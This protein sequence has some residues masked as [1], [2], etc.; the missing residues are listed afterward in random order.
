MR[1]KGSE[2]PPREPKECDHHRVQAKAC[3]F[4]GSRG[5]KADDNVTVDL[6]CKKCGALATVRIP[7]DEIDWD[8]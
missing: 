4:D 7:Y 2:G 3:A 1:P 8:S 5:A 6:Q